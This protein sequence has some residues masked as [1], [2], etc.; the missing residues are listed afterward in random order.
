[1][2]HDSDTLP[3]GS[4]FQFSHI[5]FIESELQIPATV[6]LPGLFHFK[7]RFYVTLN[8]NSLGLGTLHESNTFHTS[9]I[10]HKYNFKSNSLHSTFTR[11]LLHSHHGIIIT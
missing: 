2:K 1:M 3:Q 10:T 9:F 6:S 11:L 5:S 7:S 4:N 8:P